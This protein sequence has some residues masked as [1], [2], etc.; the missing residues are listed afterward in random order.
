M[1]LKMFLAEQKM[2]LMEQKSFLMLAKKYVTKQT[3]NV[4]EG[5]KMFA[6]ENRVQS[7]IIIARWDSCRILRPFVAFLRL[8]MVI[9][10]FIGLYW[11][12]YGVLLCDGLL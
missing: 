11:P 5:K 10:A 9:M 12:L 6:K 2:L 1:E 8:R 7:D 3:K 4:K